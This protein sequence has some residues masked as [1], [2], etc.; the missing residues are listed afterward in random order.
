MT[1]AQKKTKRTLY[2]LINDLGDINRA[3]DMK[4]RMEDIARSL[5]AY[6]AAT[7]EAQEAKDGQLD[8][9]AN[10]KAQEFLA[11]I[12]NPLQKRLL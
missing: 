9:F 3:E 6:L 2:K 1:K 8:M 10:V 12:G 7:A 5:E 4:P 11:H